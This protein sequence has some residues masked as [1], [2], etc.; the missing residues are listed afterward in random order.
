MLLEQPAQKK[1]D[2]SEQITESLKQCNYEILK[3]AFDEDNSLIN[4]VLD[5]NNLTPFE[6]ALKL[7]YEELANKIMLLSG[8]DINL[9]G[10]SPL[11]ASLQLGYTDIALKLIDMG[12]NPNTLSKHLFCPL[13]ICLDREYFDIAQKLIDKGAEINTRDDKGWT[14]LIYFAYKGKKKTVEFLLNHKANVNICN[15]D[16]WNAIVGAYANGHFTIV[17]LLNKAGARFSQKYG[18]AALLNAYMNGNRQIAKE[19]LEKDIDPNIDDPKTD[20]L[21]VL[22]AKK[23]DYEFVELFLK[24]GAN[25]NSKDIEAKE[26]VLSILAENGINNSTFAFGF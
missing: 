6:F 25:P 24:H 1:L 9:S 3:N 10:H 8:F 14:A 21:I 7:G 18:Q 12:A 11:I 20:P 22:A 19:L 23:G 2:R 4:S 5:E 17:E 13:F 16:G 26:P 15:N